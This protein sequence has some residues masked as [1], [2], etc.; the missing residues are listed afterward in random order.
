MSALSFSELRIANDTRQLEWPGNE[1]ADIAF[2]AAEVA[3]EFGEVCEAIK[4]FLRAERG[5][6]GSTAKARDVADE[7]ADALIALDLLASAMGIDLGEAVRAK[8]NFTS[9]KYGMQTR[10]PNA[11]D[12]VN[13]PGKWTPGVD[14]LPPDCPVVPLGT[15]NGVYFFIDTSGQFRALKACEFGTGAITSLFH[16]RAEYLYWAWPR[17]NAMGQV[18]SWS[19]D[20]AVEAL[21]A[22]CAFKG[23]W[24]TTDPDNSK[25]GD[26]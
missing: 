7:M 15:K 22:A 21:M 12:G 19:A 4:K 5:I 24:K 11:A 3:G 17:Q 26:A 20:K 6:A 10:L 13:A 23:I 2:R 8:F 18:S 9:D 1:Q 16:G 14:G 25:G